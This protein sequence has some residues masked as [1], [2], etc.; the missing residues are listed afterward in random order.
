M[1]FEVEIKAGPNPEVL[2]VNGFKFLGCEPP[3]ADYHVGGQGKNPK[4]CT[5][6]APHFHMLFQINGLKILFTVTGYSTYFWI[7]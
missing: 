5:L 7:W 4:T 6:S 2:N 3:T 1:N